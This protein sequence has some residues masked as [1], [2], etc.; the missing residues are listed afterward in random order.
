MDPFRL[1]IALAPLALYLLRLGMLHFARRPRLLSGTRDAA[2]LAFSLVGLA[3]IGP[4]ELFFPH[5]AA[6]RF[7]A[8]TWL[9]LLVLYVMCV[10]LWLL[11][12]RPSLVIY[13]IEESKLRPM[14]AEAV[15]SL[16][17]QARW[18][19]DCL[20]LPV[21]GVQ[22]HVEGLALGRGAMLISAGKHQDQQGWRKL[23]SALRAA[24]KHEEVR[25]NP[26]G[27]A[28]IAAG[29]LF[30]GGIAWAIIHY[31][32]A[33]NRS[34]EEAGEVIMETVRPSER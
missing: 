29:L 15:E 10:S 14:L 5:E 28:L 13:N 32:D 1:S 34:L 24:L 31:P 6:L 2:A 9:L 21:L 18:A 7:G 22:L 33:M 25:R 30:A 23:D 12:M 26:F 20:A 17:A 4:M 11:V 16:D 3:V 27:L 19:G 8:Y